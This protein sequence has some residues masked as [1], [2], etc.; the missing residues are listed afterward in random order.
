LIRQF[1]RRL[2]VLSV[3][4]ISCSAAHA[5]EV[6]LT[7]DTQVTP[8][9]ATTNFGTLANLY[10]G[11]GNTALLQFDLSTLPSG[12][13]AGQVSRATLTIFVNRV[14]AGGSVSL[15]PVTSAWSEAA[16]T[17]ATIPAIGPSAGS[18]TAALA[19]QYVTLDVTSLVQGW[20]TAPST[21]FGF[22]L[23]SAVANLLLDSKEN[24]E[25]GHAAKLDITITSTGATGAT[26]AQG[27]QGISG[28]QGV[29][30]VAG[31]LG[32][33]GITGATGLVGPIGA[34]G[35]VGAPGAVGAIGAQGIQGT[36]GAQGIQGIAG[37][38]GAAG[39]IGANGAAGTVTVASTITGAPGT[40][41]SVSNSGTA[42]AAALTF[43]V[44]QGPAGPTGATGTIGAV[45]NWNTST[46]YPVGQVVFCSTACATNGSSYVAALVNLAADPSTH[47]AVWTEIAAVGAAGPSGANG[48][49]G[50]VT[51]ASTITG[52][53]GTA[54]S[55]SN[56]GTASAAALTF[57]VPQGPTGPTGPTGTIGAVANWNSSTS[58]PVSQVIFCSTVCATNGSS[59]IAISSNSAVDPSTHPLV[60]QQIAAAGAMGAPGI[61]GATGAAGTVTSIVAGT[62]TNTGSTGTLTIGGTAAVPT[63]NVNFPSSSG[64]SVSIYGDGSDGSS[65]S[66][67]ITSNTNWVT[68]PPTIDMECANFSVSA[69]V[70]LT[71]PTGTLI[72]ATGTVTVAGTI[73]VAPGSAQGL[74]QG[75][76][77]EITASPALSFFSLRQLLHTGPSGGGNGAY[78]DASTNGLGGGSITILAAGAISITGAITAN[79]TAGIEEPGGFGGGGGGGGII[80]VASKTSIANSGTGALS[81]NGAGGGPFLSANNDAGSG[82]GGGL[83]HLLAPSGQI[84][85]TGTGKENVAAG[86]VGSGPTSGTGFGGFGGSMGGTGGPPSSPGPTTAGAAGVVLTSAVADPATLFLP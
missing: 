56:S 23:T 21:N 65:G 41:A 2:L 62:V 54:A 8:A 26:G 10:V 6:A 19:G 70:T 74:N 15:S 7:G 33:Q 22:A 71:V 34:T 17:Y 3:A 82:G 59:Y 43:T 25:T 60:W 37:V 4:S 66:C 57:T 80:I 49:A 28:A 9:R 79:A 68:S 51:V 38:P 31:P 14:N 76:S 24:D 63:V 36:A 64:G 12:L 67:D 29:Q 20:V 69:L 75:V 83:I 39:A 84:A 55:V 48:A 72:R 45:A 5:T 27:I 47:P 61:N 46:L 1:V 81:A 42:S 44:P 50:T 32:I 77:F 85:F 78:S 58:Y 53:P 16:V 73:T 52:A 18:F 30:G 86:A 11:N 35:A 40:A 13:T